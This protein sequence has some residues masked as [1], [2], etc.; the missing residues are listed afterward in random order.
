ME[1]EALGGKVALE[2]YVPTGYD[3]S[4]DRWPVAYVHSGTAAKDAG[5][6]PASLDRLMRRSVQPLI[7]VFINFRGFG[8]EDKYAEMFAKELVPLID[9]TYRTL[10]LPEARASVGHGFGGYPAWHV[11][12]KNPGLV[13]KV[14]TQSAFMFTTSMQKLELLIATA[15]DLPLDIYLEWGKYDLRNPH[16]NWD[17]GKTNVELGDLLKQRG[18]TFTG[19]EVHDGTGWSSWRNRTDKLFQ[20][21]FPLKPRSLLKTPSKRG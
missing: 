13:R 9:K 2:V 6:L 19:G 3:E 12:F 17:L 21:L 16:E 1:S 7:M 20:T 18:Y 8:K 11:T 4:H 5:R 15:G 14:G 10:A